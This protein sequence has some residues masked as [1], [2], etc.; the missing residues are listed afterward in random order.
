MGLR[1]KIVYCLYHEEGGGKNKRR[2]MTQE[3]LEEWMN[4]LMDEWRHELMV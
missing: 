2:H 4:G 1:I 3:K